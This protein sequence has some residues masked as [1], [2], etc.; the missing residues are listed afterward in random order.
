MKLGYFQASGSWLTK[1][2]IRF[3]KYKGLALYPL[4]PNKI[5]K[6]QWIQASSILS[7]VFILLYSQRNIYHYKYR[8]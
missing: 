8:V 5:Y 1:N 7:T 4:N 6:I 2:Q 3:K